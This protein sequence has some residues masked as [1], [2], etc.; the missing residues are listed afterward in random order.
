M[1][2]QELMVKNI[3]ALYYEATQYP[4]VVEEGRNWY[5]NANDWCIGTALEY[6]L[7]SEQVA[8]IV[9]ALSPGN[10]W[11]RNKLDAVSCIKAE[12]ASEGVEGF[13]S[14]TYHKL[15]KEKAYR[16]ASDQQHPLD[17][18]GGNKVTAFYK[19]LVSPFDT[20]TVCVDSHAVHIALGIDDTAIKQAPSLTVKLYEK[21]ANAYREAAERI[22]S[23]AM[24]DIEITP[25]QV[26]ACCWV[27]WRIKKGIVR[28]EV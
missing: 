15:N 24:N 6:G 3:L 7:R 19:L 10:R 28:P 25:A 27:L 21:V 16:I 17:V 12:K 20:E 11:D 23:A 18:L 13:K 1:T 9:A 14:A 22:N 4:T 26:Q 5:D 2:E 8:G